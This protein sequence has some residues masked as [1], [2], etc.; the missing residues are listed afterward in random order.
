[1]R[2]IPVLAAACGLLSLSLAHAQT[3]VAQLLQSNACKACHQPATRI[4][5]PSWQ[6]IA[7]RYGDGSKN[8]EQLSASMKNGSSGQWGL[9]LCRLRPS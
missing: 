9:C 7:Q 6:E 5:G 1:M 3:D 4:V 2:Q 8:A